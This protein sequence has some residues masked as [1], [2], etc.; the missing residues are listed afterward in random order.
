MSPCFFNCFAKILTAQHLM[1]LCWYMEECLG[2]KGWRIMAM[3]TD[4]STCK[5]KKKPFARSD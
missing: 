4:A 3:L 2:Y 5:Y 1:L